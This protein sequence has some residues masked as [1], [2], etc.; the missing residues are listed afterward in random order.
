MDRLTFVLTKS[1]RMNVILFGATGFSGRPVLDALLKA[2]H[3]VRVVTRDARKID[4][5][6]PSLKVMQGDLADE[7]FLDEVM[8]GQDAVV[9]CMGKAPGSPKD[10]LSVAS[11]RIIKAM[12]R[13]GVDRLL[14]MS[15]VGAGDSIDAQ[16]WLFR[17]VL[18]KTV[19]KWL[20]E[21]I[22]D[23]N[24]MEPRIRRSNLNW[25][26]ARF[27]NI[28]DKPK[29]GRLRTSLD[30]RRIGLSITRPDVANFLVDQLNDT[31]FL[32]K[33]PSVSN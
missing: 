6:H 26:I 4:L 23:K 11:D 7:Q 10:T 17:R 32:R 33:S 29:R 5:T 20:Q 1:N 14:V 25:T 15:N 28:V 2:N 19:L 22:D 27:P 30:G 21:I 13:K 9:N 3:H 12:E 24:V 16:P 18:L 31:Q 8:E